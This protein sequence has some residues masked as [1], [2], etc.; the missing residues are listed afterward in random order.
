MPEYYVEI[1][2]GN[3]SF[4]LIKNDRDFKVDDVVIMEVV[5]DGT[6]T[7]EKTAPRIITYVFKGGKFGLSSD[8]CIFETKPIGSIT[9]P[10]PILPEIDLAF[11]QQ[12]IGNCEFIT[13]AKEKGFDPEDDVTITL[14]SMIF[15]EGYQMAKSIVDK[16]TK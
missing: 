7:N 8:Y 5:K 12:A 3:K 2:A 11:S 16:L 9:K 15:F 6:P 13:I 1:E 4:E 14:F 10:Q